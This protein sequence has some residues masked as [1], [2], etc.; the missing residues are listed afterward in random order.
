MK[1]FDALTEPEKVEAIFDAE[2]VSEKVDNEANF[3]LFRIGNFYVEAKTSMSGMFKRSFKTYSLK[4][5]PANY[6]GELLSIPIVVLDKTHA[7]VN[8]SE[9]ANS[10]A[11]RN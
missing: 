3:Q 7:K 6:A 5:L 11:K 1:D 8:P 10:M 2:K 9:A 4:E